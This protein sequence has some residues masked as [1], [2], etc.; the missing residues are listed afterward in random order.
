MRE[1][2]KQINLK[3]TEKFDYRQYFICERVSQNRYQFQGE[4][5]CCQ[6]GKQSGKTIKKQHE[7]HFKKKIK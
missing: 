3:L 4:K 6:P 1:N 5:N 2:G 7:Q